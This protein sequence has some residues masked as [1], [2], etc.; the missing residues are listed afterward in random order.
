MK[1][2]KQGD[3]MAKYEDQELLTELVME[4]YGVGRSRARAILREKLKARPFRAIKGDRKKA[5]TGARGGGMDD[6]ITAEE[7]FGDL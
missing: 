2:R 7:F 6:P 5:T 3:E 4:A 1:K